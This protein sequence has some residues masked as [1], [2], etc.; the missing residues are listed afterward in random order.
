MPPNAIIEPKK[1]FELPIWYAAPVLLGCA[2][3]A[4]ASLVPVLLLDLV[5][6]LVIELL[7]EVS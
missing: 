6:V 3:V 7:V 4:V 5:D 1:T 2:A